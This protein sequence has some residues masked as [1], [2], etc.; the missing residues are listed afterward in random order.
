MLTG[1]GLSPA[2]GSAGIMA[3]NLGGVAGAIAGSAMMSRFGS[4]AIMLGMGAGTVVGA[5]ALRSIEIGPAFD[6]TLLFALLLVTGGLLN[7]LQITLYALAAHIYPTV[8]RATGVGS[9]ASVGRVGGLLSTFVG[10][11]ALDLGGPSAFFAVFAAAVAVT[12]VA[13]A[14][15]GEHIRRTST[16]AERQ[17]P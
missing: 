11:W 7:A 2:F 17:L 16:T 6:T 10:A 9:A 5:L 12:M 3:F 4:K 15:I 1:A 14:L 13:L 8:I